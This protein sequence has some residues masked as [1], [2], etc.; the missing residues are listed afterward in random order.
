MFISPISQLEA[1]LQRLE[2]A[3]PARGPES[4]LPN[5]NGWAEERTVLPPYEQRPAQE[6]AGSAAAAEIA[7]RSNRGSWDGAGEGLAGRGWKG[8]RAGRGILLSW[9]VRVGRRREWV[10]DDAFGR[11]RG[12]LFLGR[13]NF[14]S[15]LID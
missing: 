4:E 13:W 9:L 6:L 8:G 5:T 11:R 1:R 15:D 7:Q 14:G 2:R 3:N 12:R 10:R